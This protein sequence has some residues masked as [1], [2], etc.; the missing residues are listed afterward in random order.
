MGLIY[1]EMKTHSIRLLSLGK[2]AETK[3]GSSKGIE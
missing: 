2:A 3:I 1:E